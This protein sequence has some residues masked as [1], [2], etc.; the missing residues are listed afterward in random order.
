MK[1]KEREEGP[2]DPFDNPELCPTDA[3]GQN[4]NGA[5]FGCS[6]DGGKTFHS[7]L[8]LKAAVGTEFKAIYSGKVPPHPYGIRDLKPNDPKYKEELGN[9]IIVNSKD[10]AIKYCHL[11]KINVQ[12]GDTINSGQIIGE[13]GKSS[14]AFDDNIVPNKHLHIVVSKDKFATSNKYVDPEPYLKNKFDPPNPNEPDPKKC[15]K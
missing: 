1:E 13:T 9:F 3:A 2:V 11:S 8:D 12:E 4:K 15:K 6:R 5:R 7:G 14:N 10:F